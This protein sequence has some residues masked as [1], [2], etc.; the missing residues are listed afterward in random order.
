MEFFLKL[1]ALSPMVYLK[2]HWNQFDGFIVG[3]SLFEMAFGAE[4]GGLSVLRSFRLVCN[5]LVM[6]ARNTY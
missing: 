2:D 6:L 5:L 1:I 3:I 4:K